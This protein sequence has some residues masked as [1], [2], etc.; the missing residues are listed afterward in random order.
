M[1]NIAR[2][3]VAPL[4]VVG[5]IG[6]ACGVAGTAAAE[7]TSTQTSG[8]HSIV[9]TLHTKT[10]SGKSRTTDRHQRRADRRAH[11]AERRAQMGW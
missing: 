10:K 5:I 6:G 2:A 4:L 3:L 8:N 11:T 7:V 1:N 9:A